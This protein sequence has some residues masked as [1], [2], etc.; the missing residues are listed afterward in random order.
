MSDDKKE[1]EAMPS[2]SPD[3]ASIR[4]GSVKVAEDDFEVFKTTTDGVQFR[5]V[6][7]IRASVIFLKSQSGTFPFISSPITY[8][9]NIPQHKL[10]HEK[11]SFSPPA[12]SPSQPPCTASAQWEAHSA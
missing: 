12:S 3:H 7:W 10:T 11:Q 9:L 5:L 1:I 8:N 4:A 2:S 6:G